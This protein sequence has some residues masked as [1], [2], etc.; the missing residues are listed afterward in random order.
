[1]ILNNVIPCNFMFFLY[2]E[3]GGGACGC[4]DGVGG[5]MYTRDKTFYL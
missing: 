2:E 3:G 1:M 4:G 5:Y